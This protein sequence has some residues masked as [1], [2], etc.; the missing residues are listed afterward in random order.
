MNIDPEKVEA[1]L[2]DTDQTKKVV[3]IKMG[4]T[5]DGLYKMLKRAGE[6][7]DIRSDIVG[8]L[9][10]ALGVELAAIRPDPSPTPAEEVQS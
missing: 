8:R 10:L 2:A 5:P 6:G 7:K 3:A 4:L 1:A 9:A